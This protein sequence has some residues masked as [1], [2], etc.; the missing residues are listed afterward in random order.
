[1]A[2]AS[3][4]CLGY[5]LIAAMTFLGA[6]LATVL[7]L[8]TAAGTGKSDLYIVPQ[9]TTSSTSRVGCSSNGCPILPSSNVTVHML[10]QLPG[11][12]RELVTTYRQTS[13][14]EL[15]DLIAAQQSPESL[16]HDQDPQQACQSAKYLVMDD[17][18]TVSGLGNNMISTAPLALQVRRTP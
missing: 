9:T 5:V 2:K 18:T 7:V 8:S 17:I 6:A 11:T 12:V 16:S 13:A 3:A 14:V 10:Q 1:M 4:S 15:G